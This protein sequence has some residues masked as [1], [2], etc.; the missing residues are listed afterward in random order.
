LLHTSEPDFIRFEVIGSLELKL[1]VV[2]GDV[3]QHFPFD[4]C[5]RP[6]ERSS[7]VGRNFSAR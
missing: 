6:I 2:A 3:E 4:T 1:D 7:V 5:R